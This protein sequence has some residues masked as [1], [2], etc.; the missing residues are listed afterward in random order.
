MKVY[1]VVTTI[2]YETFNEF[3]GV[4]STREKAENKLNTLSESESYYG[5]VL[6]VEL[7]DMDPKELKI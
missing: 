5:D 1:V 4:F 3:R 7:D 6:E 2:E